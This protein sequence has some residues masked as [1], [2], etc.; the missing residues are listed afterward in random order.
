MSREERAVLLRFGTGFLLGVAIAL[1]AL[2]A[3]RSA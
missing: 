2:V 3:W 1:L